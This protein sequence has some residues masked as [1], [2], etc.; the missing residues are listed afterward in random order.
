MSER[1]HL[2]VIDDD[3]QLV[4]TVR[5][6]LESVGYRVSHAYRPE[7]GIELARAIRPDLILLDILFVGPPGPDG[8]ET[9]RR[10][11]TDPELMDIPVIV[12]SGV[13]EL[14]DMRIRMEPDET[15]MPVAAFLEK[16][17]KP[18]RLLAE[19]DKVLGTQVPSSVLV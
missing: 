18:Q 5:T 15:Y 11:R 10:L 17:F 12:L 6:L 8:L 4:D 13:K 14:L 3:V 19:I 1:K 9:S 16:P 2:L 7:K